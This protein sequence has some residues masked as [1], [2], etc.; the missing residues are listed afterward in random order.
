VEG[1]RVDIRIEAGSAD[2]SVVPAP[3]PMKA[4]GTASLAVEDDSLEGRDAFVV[5]LASDG[6]LVAQAHTVIGGGY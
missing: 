2:T 6:S 1:I 5:C 4:G 3:R